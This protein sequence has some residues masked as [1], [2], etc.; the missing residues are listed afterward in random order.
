MEK[1]ILIVALANANDGYVSTLLE[2]VAAQRVCESGDPA[3]R[4]WI[5]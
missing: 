1:P 2:Q 4:W 3:L 5:R